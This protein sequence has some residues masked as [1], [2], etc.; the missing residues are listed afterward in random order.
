MSMITKVCFRLTREQVTC[1][2]ETYVCYLLH[3]GSLDVIFEVKIIK[4]ICLGV[5]RFKIG[6]LRRKLG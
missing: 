4:K 5:I 1:E 2:T 6:A 3:F